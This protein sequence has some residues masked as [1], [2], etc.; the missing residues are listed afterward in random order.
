[1][2]FDGSVSVCIQIGKLSHWSMDVAKATAPGG[3]MNCPFHSLSATSFS[4]PSSSSTASAHHY[5][6]QLISVSLSS[7]PCSWV[8]L[9]FNDRHHSYWTLTWISAADPSLFFFSLFFLFFSPSHG[10]RYLSS[11]CR[12][13]QWHRVYHSLSILFSLPGRVF[14]EIE[15][16]SMSCSDLRGYWMCLKYGS[17]LYLF[18]ILLVNWKFECWLCPSDVRPNVSIKIDP[19]KNGTGYITLSPVVLY[20]NGSSVKFTLIHAVKSFPGKLNV[21]EIRVDAA[22]FLCNLCGL[23]IL[24][25]SY[26]H[27]IFDEMHQWKLGPF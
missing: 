20:P 8:P 13:R 27:Q 23:K 3:A 4:L 7:P 11:C 18:N 6:H 17:M 2:E 25:F 9:L 12:D 16:L 26:G 1:M 22:S 19:F 14:C 21:F 15:L 10:L 5:H 24:N